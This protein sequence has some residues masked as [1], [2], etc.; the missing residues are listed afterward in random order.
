MD[1]RQI[2]Y[3]LAIVDHGGFTRAAAALHVAQPSLSQS[4]RRLEAELGAPLFVRQG[5]TVRLSRAGEDFLG[6]ARQ[7][8][9]EATRVRTAVSAHA[10]L[11]TGT[12]DLVALPT[13]V[14]TPLAGMIGAFRRAH[15]LVTIRISEPGTTRELLQ[16]VRDGRSE[17][18]LTEGGQVGEGLVQ[19]HLAHQELLA[20]LAPDLA[21]RRGGRLSLADLATQPLILTPPGTSIRDL[22]EHA[23]RSIGVTPLVAIETSQ[24]DAIVPLVLAGAGASVLPGPLARDAGSRGAVVLPLVPGLTR[25]IALV[26]PPDDQSPAAR[27]FVLLAAEMAAEQG[28]R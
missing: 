18:G 7:V 6:P 28:S 23:L 21:H 9:R 16:M 11:I 27:A 4:I 12:L 24:R 10:A 20:V 17:I 25:T 2:E 5:R 19:V 1:L 22:V 3:A 13:L 14:A 26:H 15:P 8:L